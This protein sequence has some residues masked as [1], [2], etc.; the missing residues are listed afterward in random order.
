MLRF[1]VVVGVVVM[2][3]V[4]VERKGL[5]AVPLSPI[6]VVVIEQEA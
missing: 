3:V 2:V 6:A 1:V 5:T 4:V